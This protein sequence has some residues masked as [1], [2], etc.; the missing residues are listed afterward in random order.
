MKLREPSQCMNK[1]GDSVG[2]GNVEGTDANKEKE[3]DNRKRRSV[4]FPLMLK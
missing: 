3:R 1:E 2:L 4:V